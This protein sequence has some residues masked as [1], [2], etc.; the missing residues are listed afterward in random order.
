MERE[1]EITITEKSLNL[2]LLST[3]PRAFSTQ[4]ISSCV[5]GTAGGSHCIF[6]QLLYPYN[7]VQ[8]SLLKRDRPGIQ[9]GSSFALAKPSFFSSYCTYVLHT[10]VHKWYVLYYRHLD[11]LASLAPQLLLAC[12]SSRAPPMSSEQSNWPW[13][14]IWCFSVSV[15]WY[16]DG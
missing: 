8:K 15:A 16:Y 6:Q 11:L 2:L 5:T 3:I 9:D 1:G 10:Y 14:L 12:R 4:I 13:W 7:D